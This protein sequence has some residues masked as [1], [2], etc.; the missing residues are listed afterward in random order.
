L[1]WFAVV[2]ALIHPT[3]TLALVKPPVVLVLS[4]HRSHRV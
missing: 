1:I 3:A 2:A 4:R